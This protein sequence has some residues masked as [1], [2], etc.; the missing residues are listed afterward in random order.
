MS[1]SIKVDEGVYQELL[2]LQRPRETF[3]QVINRLLRIAALLVKV[4]P[5]LETE[6]IRLERKFAELEP[7]KTPQ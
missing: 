2:A 7:E 1:K 4:E 6:R 3:S 5:F